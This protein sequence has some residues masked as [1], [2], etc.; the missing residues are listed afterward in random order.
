MTDDQRFYCWSV[1]TDWGDFFESLEFKAYSSMLSFTVRPLYYL[2]S[3]L[4]WLAE[5][6]DP[7]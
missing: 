1:L 3:F 4:W 5:T 2:G 7:D 6:I